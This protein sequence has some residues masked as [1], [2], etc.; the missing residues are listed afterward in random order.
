M[1]V[2][3]KTKI[4]SILGGVNWRVAYFDKL[5]FESDEQ[6][7]SVKGVTS[8]EISSHPGRDLLK[9]VFKVRNAWVK[10]EWVEREEELSIICIK[11][12][13]KGKGRD[14]STERGSVH[15]EE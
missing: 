7:F 9:S 1:L 15:D 2:K 12:V 10:V 6:E 14:Q 8:K 3:D 11:L 5:V 4:L 13:V